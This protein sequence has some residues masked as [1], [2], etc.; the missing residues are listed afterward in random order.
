MKRIINKFLRRLDLRLSRISKNTAFNTQRELISTSQQPVVIFDVGAYIGEVAGE[1]RRL[2]PGAKIYC[3]E[4]FP[5]SFGK[6]KETVGNDAGITLLPHGLGEAQ[7]QRQ[8]NSNAF[9]AT[10]SLLKTDEAGKKTW[11]NGLLETLE[12]I[13]VDIDTL[14]NVVAAH[15]INQ[16]DILKLDVQG[17][18]YLV[19]E[20]GATTFAAGIVKMVYTEII[21]LPTYEGQKSFD[22]VL[23]LFRK[24]GFDLYGLY[25]FSKDAKGKLRQLDAIF[26]WRE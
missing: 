17:A 6:L 4:P 1:Y 15:G 20:G 3:F 5:D 23:A 26:V 14:D 19:L 22:E 10:N 25:N 16:I 9:A 12:T 8:I 2:F 24:L 13:T 21:V 7:G 11:G 18:E